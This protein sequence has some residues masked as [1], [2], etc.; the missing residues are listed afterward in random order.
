[1]PGKVWLFV[2]ADRNSRNLTFTKERDIM[3]GIGA[4]AA[5]DMILRK[6]ECSN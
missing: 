6:I 4:G 3:K 1:M 5:G 2:A